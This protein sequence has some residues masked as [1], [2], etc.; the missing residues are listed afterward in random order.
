LPDSPPLAISFFVFEF[1]HYLVDVRHGERTIRHP[2]QFA[3]F[4]V[5]WP[6]IVAG[7]IKRYEQFLPELY[8]AT[9]ERTK[10]DEIMS[11]A[12]RVA[13]GFLKKTLADNLTTFIIETD[14]FEALGLW[15]RW[16]IVIAI[17]FRIL[18]DFS[19]Y[20]D[21]AIGFAQMMGVKL[22]ANF[23]WP[24]SATSPAAFWRRWQYLTE[25]VDTGLHLYSTGRRTGWGSRRGASPSGSLLSLSDW[26]AA[27]AL[28]LSG[29]LVL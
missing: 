21:M 8:R 24:Y 9:S 3:L 12:I 28:H 23:N 11:G 15:P 13:V 2:L 5:F 1:V 16:L 18:L 25:F 27:R 6:S 4:S 10:T 14:H 19:G 29:V 17:A 26:L 7:P 22:P 20:S